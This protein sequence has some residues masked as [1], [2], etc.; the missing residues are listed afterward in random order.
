MSKA[1]VSLNAK[2]Y[3]QLVAVRYLNSAEAIFNGLKQQQGKND[4]HF[5]ITFRSFI[6]YTRRGIWFLVWARDEQLK[7]A[8]KLTFQ[9]SGSPHLVAMDKLINVALGNGQISHLSTPVPPINNE[10]FVDALHALTHGNPISVRMFG[11]G[12]D[13]IFQTDRLLQRAELELDW[14][15]ILLY[16]RMVGDEFKD[17]WKAIAPIQ[18]N[19]IAMRVVVLDAAKRVKEAGIASSPDAFVSAK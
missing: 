6:E 1:T 12:L 16:R 13:K 11:F 8:G 3:R 5:V 7:K 19:P 17:I 9:R 10:P 14:F 2:Q 15:R 4:F 18:S